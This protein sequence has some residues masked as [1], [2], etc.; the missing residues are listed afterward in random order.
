M[1]FDRPVVLPEDMPEIMAA[2]PFGEVVECENLGGVPNVTYEI[3]TPQRVVAVRISNHGYTSLDHLKLELE[4]LQHLKDVGF[5]ESPRLIAGTNGEILQQWK[6]YWFCATEFIP[7]KPGDEVEITPGLCHDVGRAIASLEKA[8][9]SFTGTIP[10]GETFVERA[11]R[12]LALLPDTAKRMGWQFDMDSIFEQWERA[13][14]AFI[15]N[16]SNLRHSIIHSD[17]WPPN[18]ICSGEA[19]AGIVD[20]DDWCYGATIIDVCAPLVEFPW[21]KSTT[22]NDEL[23]VAFLSGY[24]EHGGTISEAEENLIIDGIEMSCVSW[25]SCNALHEVEFEESEIYMQKLELL[26]D[27]AYKEKLRADVRGSI[28]TAAASLKR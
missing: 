25:L 27:N 23:A 5:A 9:S 15:S 19:I 3:T 10:R 7:G 4:I 14:E 11:E 6:G 22:M 21:F 2:Y 13:K 28:R 17:V 12:L 18:V 20:F 26:Q 24:L 8:L 1:H 16:R